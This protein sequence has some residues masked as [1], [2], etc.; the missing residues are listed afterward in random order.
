MITPVFH[1]PHASQTC[2][3]V[4]ED[5]RRAGRWGRQVETDTDAR[6][7]SRQAARPS[8]QQHRRPSPVQC[9]CTQAG[10]L[11]ADVVISR[12]PVGWCMP[13]GCQAVRLD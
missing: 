12:T 4:L 6:L 9:I 10:Q 1:P 8:T 11:A 2:W 13:S 3:S 7:A 5:V